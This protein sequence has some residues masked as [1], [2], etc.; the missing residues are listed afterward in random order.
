L[1]GHTVILGWFEAGS[2]NY[3]PPDVIDLSGTG[4]IFSP[5]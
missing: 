2:D 1:S 3:L 4:I 5:N